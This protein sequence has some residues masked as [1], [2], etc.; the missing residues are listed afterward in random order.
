MKLELGYT[1]IVSTKEKTLINKK[2]EVVSLLTLDEG[3]KR[4]P[5]DI[6][7]LAI[8]EKVV[9]ESEMELFVYFSDK[10]FYHCRELDK[11]GNVTGNQFLLWDDVIDETVTTLINTEYKYNMTI[12]IPI[13]S[14]VSKSTI[15]EEFISVVD[16]NYPN[17]VLD[18]EELGVGNRVELTEYNQLVKKAALGEELISKLSKLIS[19]SD[20]VDKIIKMDFDKEFTE[21]FESLKTIKSDINNIKRQLH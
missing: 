10:N 1:Y 11:D 20:I 21:T 13:D 12:K 2:I 4:V 7:S 3:K 5:Y 19:I 9:E 6:A 17:V 8:N 15:I 14:N 16:E 18:I